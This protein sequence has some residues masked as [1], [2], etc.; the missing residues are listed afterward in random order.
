MKIEIK[1]MN[2][3]LPNYCFACHRN[4]LTT[5]PFYLFKEYFRVTGNL[6]GT[7][8]EIGIILLWAFYEHFYLTSILIGLSILRTY[9]CK[10][11]Q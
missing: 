11:S 2:L 1:V 5:K 3:P 8:H 6:F 9:D 7:I 10:Y 4:C